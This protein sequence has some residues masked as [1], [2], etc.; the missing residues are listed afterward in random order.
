M[1]T[2][3]K[4]YWISFAAI[5]TAALISLA[6]AQATDVQSTLPAG[7]LRT[8]NAAQSYD[9][10]VQPAGGAGGS[11][12]AVLKSRSG[13]ADDKFGTLMQQFQ[14]NEYRGQSVR[15]SAKV[16]AKN[17][18]GSGALWMRVD[19]Q[20]GKITAFDNMVA[21][22]VVGTTDWTQVEIVL[23]V[24]TDSQTISFGAMLVGKGEFAMTEVAINAA[25]SG[26]ASTETQSPKALT[27]PAKPVN[28]DF[29]Q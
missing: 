24:A 15:F 7:W 3:M 13:A 29:K 23:P 21:R 6:Y 18:T 10:N 5:V 12:S 4:N 26:T 19:D 25:P 11:A 2:L 27:S 8:G 9:M 17:V 28:L 16:R 20:A 14:A 1:E 22:R